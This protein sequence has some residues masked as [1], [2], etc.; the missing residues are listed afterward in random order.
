MDF[1]LS[2]YAKKLTWFLFV[3]G[4]VKL[5]ELVRSPSSNLDIYLR[6]AGPES[7]KAVLQDIKQ[8]EINNIVVD[9]R[10]ENMQH[11]LRGIL[12][13]QMNDYKYHYL[14]TTFVSI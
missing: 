11:F 6:Q 3:S 12:Q 2:S 10:P 5:R 13:L 8:K 7:Y 14:F 4:L 9:T 1:F